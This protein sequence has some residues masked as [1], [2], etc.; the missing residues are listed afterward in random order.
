MSDRTP[1]LR[2]Q[3]MRLL[4][5]AP[6]VTAQEAMEAA[7]SASGL[8][9]RTRPATLRTSSRSPREDVR[10]GS[11]DLE[12]ERHCSLPPSW[13]CSSRPFRSFFTF[14]LEGTP[15]HQPVESPSGGS[16]ARLKA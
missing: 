10:G 1:P 4:D 14:D 8:E 7:T 2:T 12:S 15:R 6:T 9:Q 3:L 11:L 13:W 5:V 16:S